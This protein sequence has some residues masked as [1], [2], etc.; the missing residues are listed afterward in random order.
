MEMIALRTF[1]G[2]IPQLPA[3]LLP[4]TAAQQASFC[5][6]THGS[7]APLKGGLLLKTMTGAVKTIYTED[8]VL[9]YTWPTET[10]ALKSPVMKDEFDRVYFL[11][12][13]VLKVTTKTGLGPNG[14]QPAQSWKAGVPKPTVAP[15]LTLVELTEYPDTPGATFEARSWWEYNGERYQDAI[16][17]MIENTRLRSY[18]WGPAARAAET[19]AGAVIRGSFTAKDAAGVTIWSV[20]LE[21]GAVDVRSGSLPGGITCSWLLAT[22]S[23]T[24]H[25]LSISYGVVETRAYTYTCVN[26]WKEESAAGPPAQ[27]SNSYVQAVG[28]A[29]T[30]VDL[31]GYRPLAHYSTYRTM[32]TSPSYLR[33]HE[34][35]ELSYT[36][37]S[38]KAVDVLGSLE[39]LDYEAPPPL[40]DAMIALVG[41]SLV[42][43]HGNTLYMSEPYRPHTWQYQTSFPKAIRGVSQAPQ[44]LVVTTAEGC[45]L[46]T[47]A[48]P[49]S[50]QPFQLPVPQAGVAQRSMQSLDGVTVFASHDGIVAVDGAQ[51]SLRGSQQLFAR[52]DWQA[53]YGA[54]LADA[55][56]RF[57]WHDGSLVGTSNTAALGFLLRFDGMDAGQYTRFDERMDATFQLPVTDTLYYAIGANVYLFR[58]GEKYAYTWWSRDYIFRRHRNLGAGFIR[59]SGPVTLTLYVDGVQWVQQTVTSGHF[60]LKAG[61]AG[62]RWSVKLEGTATVEELYLARTMT[63]LQSV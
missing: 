24:D 15:A 14:G 39:T 23:T 47:G 17:G 41:G 52:D 3:H 49:A 45:Y 12:A 36:D 37:T 48:D 10:Y 22:G 53:R 25:V 43:F 59:C 16:G 1:G 44:S 4:E 18:T 38:N 30:A 7:L 60:R 5:D 50:M 33:V 61:R 46:M 51:A 56:L 42:G 21:S 40:L 28:V 26:E 13:G 20:S 11:E 34:G 6:F 27:I 29:L 31:T 9:F 57:A 62:L 58:G 54:V 35:V 19:P 55:S 8:G 32:G 2:E 63:E